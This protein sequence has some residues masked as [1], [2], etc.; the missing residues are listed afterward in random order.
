MRS[1]RVVSS[2]SLHPRT[3]SGAVADLVSRYMLNAQDEAVDRAISQ[4]P[5]RN[6][7]DDGHAAIPVAFLLRASDW[8]PLRAPWWHGKDVCIVGADCD[9]NFFLRH[10]DGSI[11]YWDHRAQADRVVAPSVRD[12]VARIRE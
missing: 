11:R 4:L 2:S 10:C 3:L 1:F 9:G 8:R 6:T 7:L 5:L 12:F